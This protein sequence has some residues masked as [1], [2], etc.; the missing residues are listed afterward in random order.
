MT[1]DEMAKGLASGRSLTQE[2]WA[3]PDE[4]QAVDELGAEGLA[5][6]GPWEYKDGF[7]CERR[8]ITGPAAQ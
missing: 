6:V 3:T 7:Q 1:K 8:I 5:T 2:E 4:I